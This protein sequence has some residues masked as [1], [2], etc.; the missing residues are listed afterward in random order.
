MKYVKDIIIIVIVVVVVVVT[1]IYCAPINNP[2]KPNCA[3]EII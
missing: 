1:I 2:G 3:K